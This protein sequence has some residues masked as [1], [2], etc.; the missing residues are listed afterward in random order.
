MF[1]PRLPP[2]PP[3]RTRWAPSWAW[4]EGSSSWSWP[5]RHPPPPPR[6]YSLHLPPPPPQC[7][8]WG[9]R[10]SE[11]RWSVL[12][13]RPVKKERVSL[14][15][16]CQSLVPLKKA[17]RFVHQ[18]ICFL[19]TSYKKNIG[20]LGD[21]RKVFGQ[22]RQSVRNLPRAA[23]GEA[24]TLMRIQT[25]LS[26]PI[27]FFVR[28]ENRVSVYCTAKSTLGVIRILVQQS[29]CLRKNKYSTRLYCFPQGL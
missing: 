3:W 14:F 21:I 5:P 26:F 17:A 9:W 23:A 12:R 16:L 19:S 28:F 2:T 29:N 22:R 10:C 27:L 7:W 1:S 6:P 13:C 20:C 15:L 18:R 4:A 11:G 24:L 8:T 25:A